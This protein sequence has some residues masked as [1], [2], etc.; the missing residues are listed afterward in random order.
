[1]KNSHESIVEPQN[2][3]LGPPKDETAIWSQLIMLMMMCR[4]LTN[5]WPEEMIKR[6]RKNFLW[7]ENDLGFTF[8][9]SSL[10]TKKRSDLP[11]WIFEKCRH[12]LD[13][14]PQFICCYIFRIR[15]LSFY[16]SRRF[17]FLILIAP[18]W[19]IQVQIEE[20]K[21]KSKV[22]F[23]NKIRTPHHYYSIF[24]KYISTLYSPQYKELRRK[25]INSIWDTKWC[26]N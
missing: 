7:T 25:G 23:V 13:H 11:D 18:F 6:S 26:N 14:P 4:W 20:K 3:F 2:S 16:A 9:F 15:I 12:Y 19:L 10:F 8:I 5:S 21:A 17:F 22:L 24:C 1:M